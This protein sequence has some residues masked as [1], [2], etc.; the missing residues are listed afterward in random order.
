MKKVL[1][2]ICLLFY[3]NNAYAQLANY[4]V[5]GRCFYWDVFDE[6]WQPM[7]NTTIDLFIIRTTASGTATSY[8]NIVTDINGKYTYSWADSPN[9]RRMV[10]LRM[11]YGQGFFCDPGTGIWE[12]LSYEVQVDMLP[13]TYSGTVPE[14]YW[15]PNSN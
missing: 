10:G 5:N 13:G 3:A 14:S 7:S 11:N 12:C 1:L 8:Y 6:D 2:F 15:W 4:S 9:N